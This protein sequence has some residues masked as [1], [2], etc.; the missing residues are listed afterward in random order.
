MSPSRELLE[1]GLAPAAM[2]S[3]VCVCAESR[4]LPSFDQELNKARADPPHIS[5]SAPLPPP[6]PP[7]QVLVAGSMWRRVD[8][9]DS[10][11]DAVVDSMTSTKGSSHVASGS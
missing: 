1:A 3:A 6:P 4:P 9:R 8:E 7:L 10:L 2:R 5:S 11:G